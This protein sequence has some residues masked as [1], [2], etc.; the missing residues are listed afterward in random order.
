MRATP[1]MRARIALQR[2]VTLINVNQILRDPEQ[3]DVVT[4][5]VK[6]TDI[7]NIKY[8]ASTML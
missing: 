5:M 2:K 6:S 3:K 1:K 8:A 7:D 4:S